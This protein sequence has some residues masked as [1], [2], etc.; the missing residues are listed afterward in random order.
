M[1]V[2]GIIPARYESSRY[3]GK[4][5]IKLLNKPMIIWVSEIVA[6]ALGKENTYVA[7]D[8]NLIGDIVEK[9]GF[10]VVM[11]SSKCLTGTDRIYEASLKIEADIYL[12]IQ[13]D[14]PLI[15][16]KDIFEVLAMKRKYLGAVTN[17]MKKLSI[18]EDPNDI[19]IP[20][21]LVNE[22]NDLIY[23]SRLAIP[24]IKSKKNERPQ[25]YKQVCIYA[26]TKE[27]LSKFAS[28]DKKAEYERFED[29]EILRLFDLGIPVKM[30]ETISNS[31][32]VDI[33]GD[34]EKVEAE[35]RRRG[36]SS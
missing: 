15:D 30:V 23:M 31:L 24:G 35:M 21:V 33:P 8:S 13:G 4:P 6:K 1:N 18:H 2:V 16:P 36:L 19:N 28:K 22:N 26:F 5:L 7:T 27:E 29:I 12:N 25:Y 20:K 10:N 34:V 32:A 9:A 17:G 3:P 14:E 11:T